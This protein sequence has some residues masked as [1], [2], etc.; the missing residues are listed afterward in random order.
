MA[1]GSATALPVAPFCFVLCAPGPGRGGHVRVYTKHLTL[2]TKGRRAAAPRRAG[3]PWAGCRTPHAQAAWALAL[4]CTTALHMHG[5]SMQAC[6][7]NLVCPLFTNSTGSAATH[8]LYRVARQ[9]PCFVCNATT[10]T[11]CRAPHST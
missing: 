3:T 6:F 7:S 1:R 9:Q 5:A 2:S 10:C 4:E 8:Q 11:S